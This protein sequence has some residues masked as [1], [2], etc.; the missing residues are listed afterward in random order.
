MGTF[1]D[2]FL[3]TR[4]RSVKGTHEIAS[5]VCRFQVNLAAKEV[6]LSLSL[7][8]SVDTDADMTVGT[9]CRLICDAAGNI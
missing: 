6:S 5:S 1:G 4:L 2:I 8:V 7:S 9:P 3:A